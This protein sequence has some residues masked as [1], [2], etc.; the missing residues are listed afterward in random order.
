VGCVDFEPQ[1]GL[2]RSCTLLEAHEL[3]NAAGR[4]GRAGEAAEGLVILVPGKVIAFNEQKN[5][6]TGHWFQLQSIF[7]N[8]DQCLEIEDPLGPILDRIH[9]DGSHLGPDEAY[10]LRRLPFTVIEAGE[11]SRRLLQNSFAAFKAQ[12]RGDTE[13]ISRRIDSSLNRREEILGAE[14]YIS[15]ED[16][17]ASSTGILDASEIRSIADRFETVG[18]PLGAVTKWVDWG[19][20]WL[21]EE[22]DRLAKVIRPSTVVSVFGKSF[23]GF[24]TDRK[25][26]ADALE[27]IREILPL[28]MRGEPLNAIEA[29]ISSKKPGKCE[30]TR[31]WALRLIPELRITSDS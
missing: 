11:P 14:D 2:C 1:P 15:W 22:P 18:E 26:A 12:R 4:A 3:L 25:K 5:T 24:D 13:W 23:A 30:L 21:Q 29:L 17:L 16:E 9:H 8:S 7:S 27:K 19:L 31:E 20:G 6:I 10:F 28:W